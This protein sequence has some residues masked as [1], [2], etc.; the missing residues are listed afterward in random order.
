MEE[1][2]PNE[3]EN[4]GHPS[5]CCCRVSRTTSNRYQV[6]VFGEL[7]STSTTVHARHQYTILHTNFAIVDEVRVPAMYR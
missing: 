7:A 2:L 4:S 5:Y 1:G 3:K 6:R